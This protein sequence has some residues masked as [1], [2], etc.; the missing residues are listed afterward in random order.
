MCN[1]LLSTHK[2]HIFYDD[3]DM[4]NFDSKTIT[5]D[6]KLV[7]MIQNRNIYLTIY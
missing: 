3:I 2:Y 4:R 1:I 7:L 6:F 5:E